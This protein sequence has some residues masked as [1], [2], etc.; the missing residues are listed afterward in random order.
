MLLRKKTKTKYLDP[1]VADI[2]WIQSALDFLKNI[3]LIWYCRSQIFE[4]CHSIV[5]N[6]QDTFG[7]DEIHKEGDVYLQQMCVFNINC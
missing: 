5:N 6:N 4:F 1:M 7:F 3:I 2:P